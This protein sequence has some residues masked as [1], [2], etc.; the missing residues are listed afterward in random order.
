VEVEHGGYL[1]PNPFYL[2]IALEGENVGIDLDE[3]GWTTAYADKL[4]LPG[5]WILVHKASGHQ[6]LVV[7]VDEGD[8]PYY[9]A[10]HV[11]IAGS[12][13]SNEVTAYG[14][15]KKRPDGVTERLW[16][17]P[18]GTVCGGDDVDA[19]GVLM[20]KRMGPKPYPEG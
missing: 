9:T 18:G 4:R 20:V 1:G 8:Q 11:G 5:Q 2:L 13:G 6:S 3:S 10:R 19:L 7:K 15:G 12:S 16:V 17:L 14:I